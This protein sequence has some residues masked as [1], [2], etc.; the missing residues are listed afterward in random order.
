MLEIIDALQ[1]FGICHRNITPLNL[2]FVAREEEKDS[3]IDNEE[4]KRK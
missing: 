1:Q 3:S 4:G 2:V